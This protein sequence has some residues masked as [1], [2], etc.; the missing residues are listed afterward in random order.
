[1]GQ[2]E[3]TCTGAPTSGLCFRNQS[4]CDTSTSSWHTFRS[5]VQ[6]MSFSP[7]SSTRGSHRA[8]MYVLSL[9]VRIVKI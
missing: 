3:S 2:G 1:M 5:P 8:H 6:M 9:V 4:G 7:R